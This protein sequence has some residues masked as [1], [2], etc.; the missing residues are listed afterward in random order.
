MQRLIRR[1]PSPAMIVACIALLVALS[2]TG[3]AA[4]DALPRNSVG[5]AQLQNNSV[6]SLKV[7]N[8]SL[9]RGDFKAGQI[10]PGPQGPQGPAGPA[11]PKG[12][13]GDK[14]DAGTIGAITVRTGTV[15]IDGG[16]KENGQYVTRA[17]QRNCD[18]G[19]RAISAG[20][21]WS[22]DANDLEL[23][24]VWMRPIFDA[25]NN[26]IGYSAKGGND[27]GQGSTFTLYVSCY[28]A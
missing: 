1:R 8:G 4:V 26:V 13:K 17:V 28:K 18:S 15:T 23:V 20:T 16:T 19:E 7:K 9:L 21:G 3:I 11:G 24:V 27:S 10:P 2:G 22:D 25:S 5:N 14:G 12:D 6:T